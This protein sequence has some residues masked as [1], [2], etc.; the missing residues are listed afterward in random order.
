MM[1]YLIDT[2]RMAYISNA[3]SRLFARNQTLY[4]MKCLSEISICQILQEIFEV[5]FDEN[6]SIKKFL[7]CLPD[8]N[9][10]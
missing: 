7:Q 1:G 8:G 9:L 3:Q 10:W 4:G 6:V 2:I 5:Y